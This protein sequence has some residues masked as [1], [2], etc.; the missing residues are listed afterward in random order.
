M[1]YFSGG[2]DRNQAMGE[3]QAR[4]EHIEDFLK[5]REWMRTLGK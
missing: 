1:Q 3:P 2:V 4:E 5:T